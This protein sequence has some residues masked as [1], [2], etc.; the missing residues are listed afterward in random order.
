MFLFVS[1]IHSITTPLWN[2]IHQKRWK[3]RWLLIS[4]DYCIVTPVTIPNVLHTPSPRGYQHQHYRQ[5]NSG[6]RYDEILMTHKS[7]LKR[8]HWSKNMLATQGNDNDTF[9]REFPWMSG[10]TEYIIVNWQC[11]NFHSCEE[12]PCKGLACPF[13]C[14]FSGSDAVEHHNE[15]NWS[16]SSRICPCWVSR[17]SPW[18]R[19]DCGTGAGWAWCLRSRWIIFALESSVDFFE[20]QSPTCFKVNRNLPSNVSSQ[21]YLPEKSGQDYGS[22]VPWWSWGKGD[23][24]EGNKVHWLF[25]ALS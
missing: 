19:S 20:A 9:K 10:R 16:L 8:L 4:S 22:W 2:M 17:C 11:R 21:Q 6:F 23:S 14:L 18:P 12:R 25:S 1:G 24:K 3:L 7:T 5:S 13:R 15:D